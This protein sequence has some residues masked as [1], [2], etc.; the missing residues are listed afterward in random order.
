MEAQKEMMRAEEMHIEENKMGTMPVNK[1]LLNMSIPMIVSMLIQALYNVVDSIFVSRINENALSAVSLVFP[2]QSIMIAVATGT[3]V[4]VNAILSKRLGEKKMEEANKTANVAVLLSVLSYFIFLIVGIFGSRLF[5]EVQVKDAQVIEYG[6]SYMSIVCIMSFGLFLQVC[7]ERLLQS[8][9]RTFYTM[10]V[11]GVG[12]VINLIMDP[13]LI[14]GL[15]GFPKM[16]I[17]GAAVATVAGQI[18]G[19]ILG[20]IFNLKANKEIHLNIKEMNFNMPII[21]EIYKIGIPAILM[22][23]I[24]SV[25]VFL[26]N[27]ILLSFTLT[28]TAV[29]GIFYKL[30]SLVFMPIFGLSNGMIPIIAYNYG[31][32]KKERMIKTVKYSMVY[33]VV[34]M[35][36][37]M[38]IAELVPGTLLLLFD[39]SE[40]MLT[41]GIPALRILCTCFA[42]A[43]FNII[44]SSM[45][46]ALGNSMY[47][48]IMSVIRQVLVLLP[49][50]WLLSLTGILDAVWL[51]FPIAEVVS[52]VVAIV[53]LKKTLKKINF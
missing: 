26:M 38:L 27:K 4:G 18:V 11:Q 46:Q 48:L 20:L 33:A 19:M 43:G 37:G 16:G 39:A 47:S 25:M 17:A 50:A 1:L 34:I 9:G 8:T 23:S 12:A 41:I 3:C 31:A 52:T 29:F 40:S 7:F 36:L 28:A 49:V 14:F 51:S 5:F 32:K 10:I 53:L 21:K 2:V 44:A 22:Q 30:Q 6:E 24:G 13:I 35:L 42:L 45:F 15:F